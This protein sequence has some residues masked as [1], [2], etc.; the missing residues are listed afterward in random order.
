MDRLWHSAYVLD[1]E[2]DLWNRKPGWPLIFGILER[3]ET[4]FHPL[5]HSSRSIHYTALRIILNQCHRGCF[6]KFLGLKK[7]EINLIIIAD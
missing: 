4:I 6:Q 7:N 5:H 1:D 2:D 3:A